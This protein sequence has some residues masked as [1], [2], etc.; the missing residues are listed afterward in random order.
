VR[1]VRGRHPLLRRVA[2]PLDIDV[3]EAFDALIIS[4]PNMGGKTV[5][6]KTVGLFCVLAYAGIPLPAAAGTIIGAFDH[7]ACVIGDEQSIA[8]NLSSFSAHLRALR[9]AQV[10]AG[11]GS[12]ILVDEIGSGT[13]PGA[14]AALAQAFIEAMLAVGARAIVTTHY[15]QLK[16]FAADRD[17]VANASML[18]DPATNEP[19]Y[20]L[21]VGVP[22]RSLAFAL[23]RAI[24]F[25]APTIGRAE[26]LLG[27]E[28]MDLERVFAS[29][30][31][32]REQFR[33]KVE[34]LEAQR[35]RAA[36]MEAGLRESL[37]KARSERIEFER[38]AAEELA[39]AVQAVEHDV[40]AKAQ[41]GADDARR[42]RIKP[43]PHADEALDRTLTEMR[44]SLGLEPHERVAASQAGPV[45][46]RTGE[47]ARAVFHVG[48]SVFVR[49]F[50]ATGI[51]ADVYERDVLVTIGNAKTVVAPADLS[52]ERPAAGIGA[53][54]SSPIR[55]GEV[56]LAAEQAAT[57]VDVRG[58]RVEE[59][60]VIVDKAL[61]EASLA[62][63]HELRVLHGK[64]TGQLGRGIRD[65]LR[66][67]LQVANAAFAADREG[68]SGVTVISLK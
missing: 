56:Q 5:M 47:S 64:G 31:D 22:G 51:V 10:R 27:A 35:M 42:Q 32:Q 16:I 36:E 21:L 4:G 13:E 26:E 1:I 55:R 18:F 19:T 29:L 8:E 28:A 46:A 50:G 40:R 3:G 9:A 61:D 11:A 38:R 45:A 44:R 37:A 24:G 15:T 57:K 6:L 12:L 63:L 59:A 2:V 41:Q 23:A 58:M 68:G 49:T 48:D 62:G 53:R 25:D 34:E 67:H 66:G 30:A 17:R 20:L 60:M 39:R 65:F 14:G 52:L 7:I 43:V 54:S 33:L